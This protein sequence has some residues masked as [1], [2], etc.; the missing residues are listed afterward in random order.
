MAATSSSPLRIV[1]ALKAV[2]SACSLR[3]LCLPLGMEADDLAR[4]DATITRR[5]RVA[6]GQH[7]YRMRDGFQSL[8]AIRSGF[9]KTY[10]INNDGREQ[11]NGF[12][13]TGEIMGLDAISGDHHTCNAVALE[14][15]EVCLIPFSQLETLL[16]DIPSLMR[17][18]HRLMSREIA[19]DHGMMMLLGT[20]SAE[21]KLAVFLSNL[22]QRLS[23]RGLSPT[24]F[25][26]SMSREEIGNYLGLK[27]ETVSRTFSKLQEDGLIHVDRRNLTIRDAPALERL[28]GCAGHG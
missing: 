14:D 21:Q 18:F 23:A 9:F 7:L 15:C 25:R 16:Q 6:S 8:Y 22:S 26:L 24:V 10:E 11:I 28:A 27:L 17:Q 4:L 19:A 12:H 20:M 13:M 3:E 1:P 2:C 5:Q